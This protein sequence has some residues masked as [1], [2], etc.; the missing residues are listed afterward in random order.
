M[1]TYTCT[2]FR[3][4]WPVGTAAVVVAYSR[5]KAAKALEEKLAEI[6]LAQIID[7]IRMVKVDPNLEHVL[8]LHDGNY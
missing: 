3:G 5:G 2:G 6:G 7:P 8:I 1:N 4:Y